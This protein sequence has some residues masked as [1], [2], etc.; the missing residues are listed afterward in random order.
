MHPA[1]EKF[2][3]RPFGFGNGIVCDDFG[4]LTDYSTAA[5]RIFGLP[6]PYAVKLFQP[7]RSYEYGTDKEIWQVRVKEFLSEHGQL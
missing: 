1:F 4:W 6:G 7:R 3:L 2:G 5:G